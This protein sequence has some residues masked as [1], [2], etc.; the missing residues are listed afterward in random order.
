MFIQIEMKRSL[1]SLDAVL[2]SLEL[3]DPGTSFGSDI[4]EVQEKLL[5]PDLPASEKTALLL[6]WA[7]RFQ[8]CLFGRL[9]ARSK[10]GI[11]IDICWVDPRD[12]A[13]GDE[14]VA[15]KIRLARRAWK[16][17]A[18]RGEAHGFLIMFNDPRLAYA[19][20]GA[21][22]LVSC[23]KVSN[24]YLPEHAPV[25]RDVIYTE[26]IPLRTAEG[27]KLFK[28][29]INLFYPSAHRTRNHDR[30]LPGGMLISVNSPGHLANALLAR[31]LVPNLAVA[32]DHMMDLA[33]RSIGNGGIGHP[34][35]ASSSWHNIENNEDDLRRQHTLS[36]LP[37]YVP[38]NHS[39][40]TYTALYHTDVLV[41]T[42][43]TVDGTI[44]PDLAACEH[45]KWL[46]LDYINT[47]EYPPDHVNYA[48]FH[49]HPIA[50][51]AKYFNPWPPRRAHNAP[52][53]N[54]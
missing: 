42:D 10:G 24:L 9:G 27:L 13:V 20:S 34:S 41:P 39:R 25:E 38:E 45:W 22:L 11:G 33:L 54:Y 19:K 31:G 6:A 23:E 44:D 28:A 8:P 12:I 46:I 14:H 17:N 26:A 32:V 18:E 4:D 3:H 52:L 15:E 47:K 50:E 53:A 29:G 43:V 1:S 51:E 2:D 49:G 16:D 21:G 40:S 37:H 35:S 36:G 48:L 5:A 30:R 7:A